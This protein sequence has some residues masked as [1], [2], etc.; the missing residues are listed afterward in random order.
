MQTSHVETLLDSTQP[1][2]PD[3][4]DGK[5]AKMRNVAI[6]VNKDEECKIFN[7][8]QNILEWN[9]HKINGDSSSSAKRY[10]RVMKLQQ[11]HRRRQCAWPM[12]MDKDR[13]MLQQMPGRCK[14]RNTRFCL[15][16][17]WCRCI[18]WSFVVM[19]SWWWWWR[20][21][22]WR[23]FKVT[24]WTVS[25]KKVL[26]IHRMKRCHKSAVIPT[27]VTPSLDGN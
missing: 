5:C 1:N 14:C 16:C 7:I 4:P 20:W 8:N 25:G 17:L 21:Q 19:A 11:R 10:C 27:V 24:H 22:C 2:P 9:W 26:N 15:W 23:K 18:H 13:Q 3:R 6:V 12:D